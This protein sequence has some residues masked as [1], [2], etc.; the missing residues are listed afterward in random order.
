MEQGGEE[1][2]LKSKRVKTEATGEEEDAPKSVF[3]IAEEYE[4]SQLPD[5]LRVY[6]TR[7]FPYD[8]YFRWLQ[9]G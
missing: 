1:L 7:I 2:G 6:Y 8:K 3:T 4:R 5:L 9:Y